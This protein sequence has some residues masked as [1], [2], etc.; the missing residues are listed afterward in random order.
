MSRDHCLRCGD[1]VAALAH[2][3]NCPGAPAFGWLDS[4]LDDEVTA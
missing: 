4:D 1:N 2:P 3:H